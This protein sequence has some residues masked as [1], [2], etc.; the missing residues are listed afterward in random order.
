MLDELPDMQL[1][2]LASATE[3]YAREAFGVH[4]NLDPIKPLGLPHFLLDRY[5]LWRG[6][7]MDGPAIFVLSQNG[8][9]GG[10]EEFLKH[11]EQMRR[12]LDASL[13]VLVLEAVPAALRRRLVEKRVAFIAPGT[14][15][16]V[17]EA[18]L[19]L[20][21]IYGSES[22]T[23][24][25][26]LSPTAQVLVLAALLG[27]E[28]ND[29]NMTQLADRYRVAIMSISRAV[30]E[31]EALELAQ[32][33]HVGRQRWLRLRL[34][35][36]ELWRAVDERLQS[37]VRKSRFVTGELPVDQA[38]L[39]G[40]SAL[41][42]YTMLAEPKIEC[43]A[44]PAFAWKRV[45]EDFGLAPAWA[46][47]ERRLEVQTWTYDPQILGTEQTADRISLYLSARHDP[48]ERIAQA[49]EQLLEPFGW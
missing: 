18:L 6:E 9:L 29:A 3:V 12:R 41:A 27:H 16:Y 23:P 11:R 38:V 32:P 35:G 19:N 7:L 13:L 40:E 49:A 22:A 28:V 5:S 4:L 42:R 21:E 14:Q 34:D 48:D 46:H 31:L 33:H 1:R 44:V 15:F 25:E 45:S 8:S 24:A 2:A 43:R 10:V 37:P 26:Q 20:R 36:A 17:P 47:D 30:D 39:A